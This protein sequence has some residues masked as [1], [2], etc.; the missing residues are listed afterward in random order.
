MLK[1]IIAASASVDREGPEAEA[2]VVPAD[3]GGEG[4]DTELKSYGSVEELEKDDGPFVARCMSEIAGIE[5]IK[6]KSEKVY[7][8][9]VDKRRIVP[10]HTLL[11]GYG[12]GK[13]HDY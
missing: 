11:G 4:E 2:A 3:G 12:T 7:L 13:R 5:V 9:S 10:K 8:V 6:G 1:N